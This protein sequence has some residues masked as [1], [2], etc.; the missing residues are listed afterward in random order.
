MDISQYLEKS[1]NEAKEKRHLVERFNTR[2]T[3]M[4]SD[5]IPNKIKRQILKN[6]KKVRDF[7]F[8]PYKSYGIRLVELQI[9]KDS[10]MYHEVDGR[11]Y[12]SIDDFLGKDSTGNEIWVVVRNNEIGTIMLRKDIQPIEKLRVDKVLYSTK[13]LEKIK[14]F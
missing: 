3:N 2:I 14:Q 13:E 10:K 9:N 1:I 12:Y 5:A 8:D 7:N 4:P 11:G 6:L